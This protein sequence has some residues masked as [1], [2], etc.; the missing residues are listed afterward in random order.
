MIFGENSR[1]GSSSLIVVMVVAVVALAGML[2]YVAIDR[3]VLTVDGYALPGS[4]ITLRSEET[5]FPS[6]SEEGVI[7][8]YSDGLYYIGYEDGTRITSY[9]IDVDSIFGGT[10]PPEYVSTSAGEVE[11]PGL[12]RTA[13]TTTIVDITEPGEGT[14]RIE[15]TSILHGLPFSFSLYYNNGAS[16]DRATIEMVSSDIDVGDYSDVPEISQ[17]FSGS[18]SN[19]VVVRAISTSV[20]GSYLYRMTKADSNLYYVGNGN[21]IPTYRNTGS[22]SYVLHDATLTFN[23]SGI[24][25]I[26]WSGTYTPQRS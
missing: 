18:S 13:C 24:T 22:N 19:N 7:Y 14:M 25:Q 2:V 5:G 17:T 3:N 26:V 16:E 9:D 4:S 8:G 21:M 1:R 11:V 23:D 6:D 15:Y 20:D 12:G 10:I